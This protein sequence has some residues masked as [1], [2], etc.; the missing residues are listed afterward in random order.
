MLLKRY[1]I[2]INKEKLLK[3]RKK[4]VNEY[5]KI[6]HREYETT[7]EPRERYNLDYIRNYERQKVSVREYND[8]YSEDED[9]YLVKYDEYEHSEEVSIIDRLVNYDSTVIA[10]FL[11]L[12][13]FEKGEI[14]NDLKNS[15]KFI[16]KSKYIEVDKILE[17][18]KFL[19]IEEPEYLKK[20]T[21]S[22]KKQ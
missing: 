20:V 6:T 2:I 21:K 1:E 3:L 15:V 7:R 5:S 16:E 14:Y 9:V 22:L 10:R 4:F 11:E 19:I 18:L 8:F 13:S 12:V 17:V